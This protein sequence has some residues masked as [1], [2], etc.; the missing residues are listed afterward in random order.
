VSSLPKVSTG[1]GTTPTTWA[2]DAAVVAGVPLIT[3]GTTYTHDEVL[4][5]HATTA[6]VGWLESTDATTS[7]TSMVALGPWG[8]NLGD[9]NPL[10]NAYAAGD[11]YGTRYTPFQFHI[12]KPTLPFDADFSV[13]TIIWELRQDGSGDYDYINGV[14]THID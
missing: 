14:V 13:A 10:G 4:Y 9:I 1:S 7:D 8:M 11:I 12:E 3:S 5:R 2:Q 6:V